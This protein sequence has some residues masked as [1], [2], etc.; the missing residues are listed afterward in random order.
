MSQREDEILG[1]GEEHRAT[2]LEAIARYERALEP[3][4][5]S[6]WSVV[7]GFLAEVED[8]ASTRLL[9]FA[10]T[11]DDMLTARAEVNAVRRLR[12]LPKVIASD[13]LQFR[14]DLSELEGE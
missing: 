9:E 6:G 10:K 14:N 7:D 3:L 4:T 5:S 2:L 11:H 8:D 13:L 12:A 1:H